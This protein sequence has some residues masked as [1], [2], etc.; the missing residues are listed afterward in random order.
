[1]S[2]ILVHRVEAPALVTSPSGD[3]V[4]FRGTVG[5]DLRGTVRRVLAGAIGLVHT[6]EHRL[7]TRQHL[8]ELPRYLLD[9]AGLSRD[10][11]L[12]E[13]SKPFWRP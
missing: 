2:G 12:E 1:M 7:A 4:G 13:T 5:K 9:D 8:S 6:W 11:V 10:D 3:R